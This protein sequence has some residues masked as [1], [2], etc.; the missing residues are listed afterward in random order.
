[1]KSRLK[2]C[3]TV[4]L[5]GRALQPLCCWGLQ[6]SMPSPCRPQSPLEDA[7][8]ESLASL[9]QLAGPVRFRGGH[10][11]MLGAHP[12]RVTYSPSRTLVGQ[13]AATLNNRCDQS[14]DLRLLRP[15]L[16]C[17]G[18][19][20][21]DGRHSRWS[22][23]LEWLLYRCRGAGAR[24][25]QWQGSS[26]LKPLLRVGA[27]AARDLPQLQA[28]KEAVSLYKRTDTFHGKVHA[29]LARC[30]SP[31]LPTLQLSSTAKLAAE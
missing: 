15:S 11:H 16:P 26:S 22:R 6:D 27:G 8:G 17:I 20:C 19:L 18:R 21:L 1:M 24:A 3:W 28:D 29:G 4:V 7:A 2:T 30:M 10:H 25:A 9:R 13:Q 23:Q 12:M 14:A 31:A 5:Q